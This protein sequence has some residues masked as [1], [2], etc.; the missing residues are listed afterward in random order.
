[1][2]P[3]HGAELSA[4]R[5]KGVSVP[6]PQGEGW[7]HQG[8][9]P[10][11]SGDDP[12]RKAEGEPSGS[13]AVDPPVTGPHSPW[14]TRVEAAGSVIPACGQPGPSG[15]QSQQQAEHRGLGQG[16][17]GGCTHVG[18]TSPCC[19]PS[20]LPG[21]P[22]LLSMPSRRTHWAGNHLL[23]LLTRR[24]KKRLTAGGPESPGHLWSLGRQTELRGSSWYLT[25]LQDS[26]P[27]RGPP[28]PV[29][30]PKWCSNKHAKAT[31]YML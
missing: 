18:G 15:L 13:P 12:G 20:F 17:V 22:R 16:T 21:S 29:V 30:K 24:I 11:I 2:S 25:R 14:E 26:L 28:F 31:Q 6:H 27:D 9:Q 10:H 7:W 3:P 23:F 19:R 4:E 5:R 1:M 8:L